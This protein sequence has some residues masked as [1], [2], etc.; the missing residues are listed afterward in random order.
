MDIAEFLTPDRVLLDLKVRDKAGA[1]AEIARAYGR[2]VPGLPVEAVQSALMAR[3]QLGS[4]GLGAGFSLPHARV[5]GADAYLGLFARLAKP[6]PFNSVD[7]KPVSLMFV[8][9]IP[10]AGDSSHLG[11]LAAISRRFREPGFM[12]RMRTAATPAEAFRLLT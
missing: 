2:S 6:I 12:A 11:A 3:E 5:H 7:D 4:T 1:I 9:L 8:L 10:E